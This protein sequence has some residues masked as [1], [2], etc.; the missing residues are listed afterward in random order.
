VRG[1]D[2]VRADRDQ[3]IADGEE[4][5]VA[6]LGPIRLGRVRRHRRRLD[7]RRRRL[8]GADDGWRR[9][10]R[11]DRDEG[12]GG[13]GGG[14]AEQRR[15]RGEAGKNEFTHEHTRRLHARAFPRPARMETWTD[16]LAPEGLTN[17]WL[18]VSLAAA[19]RPRYPKP[20]N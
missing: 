18:P 10:R 5:V 8:A 2:G 20:L 16:S 19:P 12:G 6:R 15:G 11:R 9:L 3:R 14:K 13:A 4:L 7:R 1:R 17:R